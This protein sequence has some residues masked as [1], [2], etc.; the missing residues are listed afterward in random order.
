MF[1]GVF[2][3]ML[4]LKETILHHALYLLSIAFIMG[5]LAWKGQEAPSQRK[6]EQ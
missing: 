4:E 3:F 5:N 1:F 2:F 6:K